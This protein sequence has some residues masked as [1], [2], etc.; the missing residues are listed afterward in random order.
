MLVSQPATA[1]RTIQP[2]RGGTETGCWLAVRAIN[3]SNGRRSMHA[4]SGRAM[5]PL[6]VLVAACY[7]Y[8]GWVLSLLASYIATTLRTSIYM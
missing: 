6:V 7:I 3:E 5:Y 4:N 2:G 1:G 8:I